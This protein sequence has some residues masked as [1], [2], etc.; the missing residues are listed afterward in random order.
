MATH[1][2]GPSALTLPPSMFLP[3]FNSM[4]TAGDTPFTHTDDNAEKSH[5]PSLESF[6]SLG[7]CSKQTEMTNRLKQLIAWQERQKASLLKQQQDEITRL[8]RQQACEEVEWSGKLLG[9]VHG[10]IFISVTSSR[11]SL[12]FEVEWSISTRSLC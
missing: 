6:L 7:I 11:Q 2:V 9:T 3:S 10:W 8:Q 1:E 4:T 12:F 5:I